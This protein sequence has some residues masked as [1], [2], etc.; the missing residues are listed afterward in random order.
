[1]Y[2]VRQTHQ[3]SGWFAKLRDVT[4]RTAILARIRR[5]ALGHPGDVKQVGDGVSELR[6]NHGPGYRVYFTRKGSAVILLLCGGDKGSQDRD[7]LR[8][9]QL[10]KKDTP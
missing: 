3:F 8:A 6:V 4:A 5:L 2:D 10:A 7:I 9:K 1:M